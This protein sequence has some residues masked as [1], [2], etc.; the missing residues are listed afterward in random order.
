[1]A[2]AI[3]KMGGKRYRVEEGEL[4]EIK[5]TPKTGGRK[6]RTPSAQGLQVITLK[7]TAPPQQK[8]GGFTRYKI[9]AREATPQEQT[10]ERGIRECLDAVE[11]K[12][13]GMK[14]AQRRI[15]RLSRQTRRMID[16]M[17]P[18]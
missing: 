2:Y 8:K 3:I 11:Q 13:A 17:M 5:A 4:L 10:A 18:E 15:S 1:M 14:R 6:P 7:R 16:E 12:V 9:L